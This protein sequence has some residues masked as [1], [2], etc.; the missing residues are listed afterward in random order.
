MQY[1]GRYYW[2]TVVCYANLVFGLI[3]ILIFSGAVIQSD[4]GMCIG[5]VF[6]GFSNGIGVTTTLIALSKSSHH[7]FQLPLD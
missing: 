4:V 2:L 5:M 7:L 6:C 3:L 1:F